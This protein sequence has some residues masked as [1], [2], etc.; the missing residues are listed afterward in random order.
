[1]E[2]SYSLGHR[3]EAAV[4]LMMPYAVASAC[5]TLLTLYSCGCAVLTMACLPLPAVDS[6]FSVR[7][8]C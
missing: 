2:V 4:Y 6:I 5:C 3:T 7:S 8:N 1:M